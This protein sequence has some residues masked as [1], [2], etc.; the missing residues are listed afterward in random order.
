[1]TAQGSGQHQGQS[2]HDD[3]RFAALLERQHALAVE[4]DGVSREQFGLVELGDPAELV[5][6]M[7]R[8]QV[9]VDEIVRNDGLLAPMHR[10]MPRG[11]STNRAG[12]IATL[13]EGVRVRDEASRKVLEARRDA[14]AREIVEL[15]AGKRAT[16]A[17]SQGSTQGPKFQDREA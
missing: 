7:A 14:I 11:D 13:L 1:M 5:P 15:S 4:L 12:A 10:A 6:L 2:A 17:Y 16:G 9:L 3:A 8:R